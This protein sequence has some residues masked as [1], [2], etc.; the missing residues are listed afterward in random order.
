MGC[1]MLLILSKQFESALNFRSWEAISYWICF[2]IIY[3]LRVIDIT[4]SNWSRL[5]QLAVRK[6]LD[7][8]SSLLHQMTWC[9]IWWI[10]INN[11]SLLSY[12]HVIALLIG[13]SYVVEQGCSIHH[14]RY[15][16]RDHRH[17][18]RFLAEMGFS[19]VGSAVTWDVWFMVSRGM[20]N[21]IWTKQGSN[22]RRQLSVLHSIEKNHARCAVLFLWPFFS[23]QAL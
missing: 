3:R 4:S 16:R 14:S 20:Q 5:W 13:V 18:L 23:F 6:R 1:S 17:L 12:N 15:S 7:I 11:A 9:S 19:Y 21:R 10:Y 2:V 22:K 8:L